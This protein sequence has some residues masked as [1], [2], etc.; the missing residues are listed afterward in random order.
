VGRDDGV[1]DVDR[2]RLVALSSISL[3]QGFAMHRRG[4]LAE[5]EELLRTALD[6][7]NLYGY[8]AIPVQ[9]G[10]AF[11]AATLLERG[12]RDG[13][14]RVLDPRIY[15]ADGS[16]AARAWLI[17]RLQ[18]LVAEGRAEEALETAGELERILSWI[19]NPAMGPWRLLKAEAL[20]LLGRRDEALALAQTDLERARHFGAP[21]TVGTALRVLG[22]LERESGLEHLRQAVEVL[23]ES[24]ARL[25][26]AKALAALGAALR[27]SGSRAEARVPLRRALDLAERCGA[28]A[29]AERTRE[30]LRATGARPRRFATHGADALTTQELRIARPGRRWPQQ[31][32]NR[33]GALRDDPYRRDASD[34]RLPEARDRLPQAAGAGA[35]H[36]ARGVITVSRS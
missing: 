24:P 10:R 5:A 3:W 32:R 6:E 12:D 34:A 7:V 31:P 33:P 30:E 36:V 1:V 8:G 17:A 2:E 35:G 26:H 20:G 23:S 29:L 25:E 21:G 19:T 13:A 16:Y 27:R 14:W 22:T 18:L 4:E 15:A 11:L 9:A 28:A